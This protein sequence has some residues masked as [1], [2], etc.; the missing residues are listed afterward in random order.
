[1]HHSHV[2]VD[3]NFHS[4]F[5]IRNWSELEDRKWRTTTKAPYFDN[6]VPGLDL[7]LPASIAV[8]A[9]RPL[10]VPANKP[11]MYCN[12]NS[13][14]IA[15]AEI[16][17]NQKVYKCVNESVEITDL[18]CYKLTSNFGR[19]YQKSSTFAIKTDKCDREKYKMASKCID[20]ICFLNGTLQ[21]HIDIFCNSTTSL[22]VTNNAKEMLIL[23]CF[24][25]HLPER[26]FF[27]PTII[28]K[29]VA[30][31]AQKP[32]SFAANM[33]VSLLKLLRKEK[34]PERPETT[35]ANRWIPEAIT[36]PSTKSKNELI[37]DFRKHIQERT[38]NNKSLFDDN[39]Y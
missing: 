26:F 13:S 1:M 4:S 18:N 14:E 27:I 3:K 9:A 16:F 5:I 24:E 23:T 35:P 19:N 20:N 22:N 7:T 34:T 33:H 25:R 31:S 37:E 2:W 39:N 21:S 32:L 12:Q 10:N 15:Q 29:S 30:T 28:E 17:M 8:G 11:L 36:F 38:K 6:K